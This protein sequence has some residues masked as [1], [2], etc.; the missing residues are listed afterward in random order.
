[1]SLD[2]VL[3]RHDNEIGVAGICGGGGVTTAMVIQREH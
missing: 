3:R 2:N 1:M